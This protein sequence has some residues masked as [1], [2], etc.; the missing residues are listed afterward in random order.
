MPQFDTFT[1]LSQLFWV[2]LSFSF[3]YLTFSFYLLPVLAVTLKVRSRKHKNSFLSDDV[4]SLI[5]KEGKLSIKPFFFDFAF[6]CFSLNSSHEN[7][8]LLFEKTILK[9]FNNKKISKLIDLTMITIFKKKTF[10]KK[11][12]N[13]SKKAVRKKR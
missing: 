4:N 3:L 11:N 2:F 5:L 10:K 8:I 1:F 9:D 13:K 12:K 7:N 6:N